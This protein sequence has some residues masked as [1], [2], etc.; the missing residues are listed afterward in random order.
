MPVSVTY[1]RASTNRGSSASHEE[2]GG[3]LSLA[4]REICRGKGP[5]RATGVLANLSCGMLKVLDPCRRP[6]LTVERLKLGSA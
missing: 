6:V 2:I 4:S 5:D 3:V 1:R